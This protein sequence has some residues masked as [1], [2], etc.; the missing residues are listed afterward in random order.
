MLNLRNQNFKVGMYIRLSREDGDKQESE[1]ISNQRK[2]LQR[3]VKEN[4]LNC[5]KEYV[6]DGVSGTTF[7]RPGFKEMINDI[8]NKTINMIIT[9]DLSR[10][11]RDYITVGEYTE[12]YF[13]KNNIR[14]VA[15]TDGID[16]YVDSTNNDITPFKA[17]M[18]DMYAKDISKKIRSVLKEKQKNGEYMCSIPA[19]GYKRHPTIK[20]KLIVDEQ[21]RYVVEKIFDMYANEH[22][23]VEIVN[24]LNNNHFLSPTGYR[25]TGLIQDK[26]K[27][28]YNWN[29]VT[30][31]NMLK[32]EV[33]IGNTIQNKRSIIS[34]KVKKFKKVN[35][36]EHIRVDNT[37]EAIIDKDLFEKVQCIFER[38]GTNS[39]LKYDY[40]LRGLLYC[41]HC[42][43]KLQIVLKKNSKRNTK[44]HPYIT[45]SDAKKRGCYP[46]NMNYEKFE[47]HIIYIVKKICQIYA[48][49]EIFY[50][51]YE[52]YQNK[53][54][55][56]REGYKK[57]IEKIDKVIFD[58]NN[59][60]DKMYMDKL[61]GV[62]Q[63][64]DY[65]R[66]SQKFNFER[67]KLCNQKK[68]LEQKL[69]GT[70]EKINTKNKTKEEKEL[71]ELIENFLKFN[72]PDKIFLY[73]LINKIE[74]DKDK[75]VYIYFNFSKLNSINENLDE[76]IKIEELI[77]ENQKCKVV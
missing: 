9:K 16:T 64:E 1:S 14:Y 56:I 69:I 45:C 28:G 39:K 74:I 38:R 32:N 76:F 30:L 60:L 23:S 3:Y 44:S 58:I 57:K 13:P 8:E 70:E 35:K 73:R 33:Y 51:I 41:Y 37:H 10:L 21:V 20:N 68:E 17:I 2:I 25:K 49:K 54:L 31:C 65:V 46:L 19:Y 61:R 11:G 67:T 62:L 59:N 40:L 12:K 24:Y 22:G 36:E 6:D 48:D 75:N 50:S 53:T 52:K 43:R 18:N 47:K 77:N 4:N 71:D 42:K 55:D 7:D 66:V 27:N 5:V 72:N 34:Y 26:N 29:E 63:E 15:L